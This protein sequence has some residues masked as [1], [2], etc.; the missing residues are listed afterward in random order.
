MTLHSRTRL[1]ATLRGLACMLLF[2]SVV[3]L[4]ATLRAQNPA[5]TAPD[6]LRTLSR[7]ELD[8]VK[9]LTRQEDAWN[10][11]DLDAFATGYKNSPDI[12]FV[13]RQISRGYD[14]MLADYK[15]NYPNKDAMG[16]LSF[17]E[18]EP[19]ILDEHYAVVLG[20][21]KLERTKKAGGNAEGIFSLVFEKTDTGWKIIVD[22]TTS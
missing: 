22:H 4:P 8:I 2:S 19:H 3:L 6:Q 5:P 17:S 9:V 13:G 20:H 1:I 21:Y 15:H 14:Q 11:G 12:L 7:E 10:H 18:L 16:T